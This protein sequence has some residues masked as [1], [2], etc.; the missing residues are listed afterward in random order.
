MDELFRGRDHEDVNDWA[1]HL[2][3]ATKVRDLND[4]KLFKIIKLNFH[5]QVKEWLKKL[6]PPP[7]NWIVL[8]NAIVQNFGDVDADEIH[9]KFDAIKQKPREWVEKYF[10]RLDKLFQRGKIGDVEQRRKFLLQLRP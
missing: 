4:D 8:K 5:G 10:E 9:V 6:N 2:T 7:A 1:E 3:M